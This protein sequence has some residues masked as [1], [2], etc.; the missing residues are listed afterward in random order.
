MRH[1]EGDIALFTNADGS[2]EWVQ[3]TKQDSKAPCRGC[4]G[5][6]NDGLCEK[7]PRC[8]SGVTGVVWREV[9]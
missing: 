6:H 7:L 2:T 3:A 9:V 4:V 1:Y 8:H 5:E